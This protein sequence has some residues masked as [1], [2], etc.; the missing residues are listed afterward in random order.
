M[1]MSEQVIALDVGGS[2]VKSGRVSRALEVSGGRTDPI[3]PHGS[4]EAILGAFA[5]IVRLHRAHIRPGECL[6]VAFGFPGPFDYPGGV[7]YIHNLQKYEAIY[8]CN[9]R[10]ALCERLQDAH[11]AIVFRNDAEAAVVGEACYGAGKDCQR[12]IGITLGTG[13][14]SSQLV[15]GVPQSGGPGVPAEGWLGAVPYRGELADDW[16]STRGLQRRMGEIA[17]AAAVGAAAVADAARRGDAQAATFFAEFGA[18]LG[19]FL[20]PFVRDFRADVVLALGGISEALDVFG[21]ALAAQIS[22]PLRGGSL[23]ANAALFGAAQMLLAGP[24]G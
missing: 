6:G 17:G 24:G 10:E 20:Q 7:S 8:E 15:A 22:V 16:F 3:D 1:L 12:V 9:I 4:A 11:L 23:G 14:G 19:A 18:E 5:E 13:L 2:S 21:P